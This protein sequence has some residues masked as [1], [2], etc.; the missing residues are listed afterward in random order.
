MAITGFSEITDRRLS[1]EGNQPWFL[2]LAITGKCNF[3][4]E[5]RGDRERF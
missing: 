1:Y 3:S 5:G 4:R 2:E